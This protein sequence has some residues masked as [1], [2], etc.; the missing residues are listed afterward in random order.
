MKLPSFLKRS[1]AADRIAD[2]DAAKVLTTSEPKKPMIDLQQLAEDFKTLDPKD[3]GLWPVIPRIVILLGFFAALI[4]SSWW[5]GWNVQFEEL[6]KKQV[7]EASLKEEWLN[8]KKQAVNLDKHKAQLVDID[9]SFGVLLKQLPDRSEMDALLV[10]V[11]KAAQARGL[12]VES[13]VLGQETG[14]EFYAEKSISLQLTGSYHDIGA[15][16]GDIAQLPRIVTLNEIDLVAVKDSTLAMKTMA[17]TFRFLD[18][19]EQA[20]QRKS[21]GAKKK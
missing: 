11:N 14:R 17:K 3:P 2:R 18:E 6:E 15:F 10:D 20:K 19:A 21:Q 5:F 13:F 12:A 4:A 9:N 1:S 8:K 16:A 7:E